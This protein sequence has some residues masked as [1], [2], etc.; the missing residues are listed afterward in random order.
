MAQGCWRV[1]GLGSNSEV[2]SRSGTAW[3][4]MIK[5]MKTVQSK[6]SQDELGFVLVCLYTLYSGITNSFPLLSVTSNATKNLLTIL[7]EATVIV[8]SM[9][10]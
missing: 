2:I 5:T 10:C 6:S 8:S 1:Q 7:Y 3:V 9:T 4:K